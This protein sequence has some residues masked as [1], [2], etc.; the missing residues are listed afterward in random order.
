MTRKSR[1]FT[2]FVLLGFGVFGFLPDTSIPL[3]F[4]QQ[5]FSQS[6][7]LLAVAVVFVKDFWIKAFVVWCF[8]SLIMVSM[9]YGSMNASIISRLDFMTVFIYALGY[10]CL[11]NKVSYIGV[12]RIFTAIACLAFVQCGMMLLQFFDIWVIINPKFEGIAP[13]GFLGNSNLAGA[14]LALTIPAFLREKWVWGLPI[15]LGFLLMSQS[16]GGILAGFIGIAF[17]VGAKNLA[18]KW[19]LAF[20][21]FAVLVSIVIIGMPDTDKLRTVEIK[22]TCLSQKVDNLLD[23]LN[24]ID[25]GGILTGHTRLFHLFHIMD[26]MVLRKRNQAIGFYEKYK[27][28]MFGWGIGQFKV[29][30]PIM[31]RM[32][33]IYKEDRYPFHAP[34]LEKQAHN[35]YLQVLVELG[36]VGLAI[37]VFGLIGFYT[38]F[39]LNPKL[40]LL[41]FVGII[42]ACVNSGVHFLFHTT[43]AILVLTYMAIMERNSYA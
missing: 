29:M 38:R 6:L 39:T 10:Q 37:V 40:S 9:R 18:I 2:F 8:C 1:L 43:T 36:L 3:R 42:I 13:S 16:L 33:N 27:E 21:V 5:L 25:Y 20:V 28:T 24:V 7:V 35:E 30:Y 4:S 22:G 12:R 14:F 23:D 26:K 34:N 19:D 41:P 11:A 31:Q 32:G 17:Y 15:I